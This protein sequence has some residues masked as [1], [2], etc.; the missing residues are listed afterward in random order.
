[1]FGLVVGALVARRRRQPILVA[2]DVGRGIL[3]AG[4]PM[5]WPVGLLTLPMLMVMVAFGS[6]RC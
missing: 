5:L 3:L 1:L 4:I 6:C 2:S